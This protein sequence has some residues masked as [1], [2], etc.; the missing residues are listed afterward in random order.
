MFC[1]L[2]ITTKSGGPWKLTLAKRTVNVFSVQFQIWL[3]LA[4]LPGRPVSCSH[5]FTVNIETGVCRYHLTKLPVQDLWRICVSNWR[6]LCTCPLAQL[7]FLVRVSEE[8][9]LISVHF[10]T[11]IKPTN[12][13]ATDTPV[14]ESHFKHLF[15]QL[16]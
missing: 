2:C 1:A 5:L 3:L 6:L 12:A 16:Y 8:K 15:N 9:Y 7:C 13:D 14:S 10:E 11:K 4:T